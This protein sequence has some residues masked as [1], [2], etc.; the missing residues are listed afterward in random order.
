[1]LHYC[2]YIFCDVEITD[3]LYLILHILRS[4]TQAKGQTAQTTSDKQ[5]IEAFIRQGV[6]LCLHG[7][8]DPSASQLAEDADEHHILRHLP[9][10]N[11]HC[12]SLRPRRN[13][14]VF[15]TKTDSEFLL[16]DNDSLIFIDLHAIFLN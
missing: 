6:R 8:G 10:T 4:S 13:N 11:S 5:R 1:M 2:V 7:A 9:D 16:L 3:S 15:T 14:F 12:C